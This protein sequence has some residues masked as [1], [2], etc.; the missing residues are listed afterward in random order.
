M[1]TKGEVEEMTYPHICFMVDNFDEVWR[2]NSCILSFLPQNLKLD[3]Y[4][5]SRSQDSA[6]GIATGYKLAYLG[7]GVASPS[8]MKNFLFSVLYRPAL[9][10]AQ[11]PICHWWSGLDLGLPLKASH[12]IEILLKALHWPWAALDSPTVTMNCTWGPTIKPYKKLSWPC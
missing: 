4:C 9:G 2:M 10:S 6:F 12:D 7:V 11:L 8:R 1:D 5:C 3:W